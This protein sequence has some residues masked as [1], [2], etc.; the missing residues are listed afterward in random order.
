MS[1]TFARAGPL[2][3]RFG[4]QGGPVYPWMVDKYPQAIKSI[5]QIGAAGDFK[6]VDSASN[7]LDR[8]A[9]LVAPK[10]ADYDKSGLPPLPPNMK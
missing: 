7:S 8:S 10:S 1:G 6:K 5:S 9:V 4:T 2:Q 3:V